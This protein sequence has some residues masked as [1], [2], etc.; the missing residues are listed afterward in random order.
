[1][2]TCRIPSPPLSCLPRF[3]IPGPI[4]H[5]SWI[6]KVSSSVALAPPPPRGSQAPPT[7]GTRPHARDHRAHPRPR[8]ATDL[9]APPTLHSCSFFQSRRV[10]RTDGEALHPPYSETHRLTHMAIHRYCHLQ[11]SMSPSY[12]DTQ[13]SG[14][15]TVQGHT[16]PEAV[17]TAL[18]LHSQPFLGCPRAQLCPMTVLHDPVF[19]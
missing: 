13:K 2:T 19:V 3:G 18:T 16:V 9:P 5:S 11:Q 12:T 7:Q 17:T 6:L 1:M 15:S 14:S 10:C 8:M 4:S